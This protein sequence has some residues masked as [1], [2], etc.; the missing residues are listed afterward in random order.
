M[1]VYPLL[2]C[3]MI[4]K[5][6]IKPWSIT[7]FYNSKNSC[8][9]SFFFIACEILGLKNILRQWVPR[10]KVT[11]CPNCIPSYSN[12]SSDFTKSMLCLS[13]IWWGDRKSCSDIFQNSSFHVIWSTLV[14]LPLLFC[15]PNNSIL[16]NLCSYKS[17]SR[18]F[19][20]PSH[21]SYSAVAFL[22]VW[23]YSTDTEIHV[24]LHYWCEWYM[25]VLIFC[26]VAN[27]YA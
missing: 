23:W 16:F 13:I 12:Y 2:L 27:S 21:N 4:A 20:T 26:S 7:F 18:N 22:I 19:T 9:T 6:L 17:I 15:F 14:Y 10:S 5:I 11:L 8:D 24:R 1:K 3:S 25:L